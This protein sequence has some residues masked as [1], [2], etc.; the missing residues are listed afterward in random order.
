MVR[1][2]PTSAQEDNQKFPLNDIVIGLIQSMY[3]E[4]ARAI[5]DKMEKLRPDVRVIAERTL[6]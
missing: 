1:S 5:I 6:L 3:R 2:T 4:E